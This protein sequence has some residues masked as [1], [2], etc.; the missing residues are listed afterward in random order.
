MIAHVARLSRISANTDS[1]LDL[2]QS[3]EQYL[4]LAGTNE[5]TLKWLLEC[6]WQ[7]VFHYLFMTS[8]PIGR[9]DRYVGYNPLY[10]L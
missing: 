7:I 2:V 8:R 4:A 10:F 3:P 5:A 1:D 6:G 9:L